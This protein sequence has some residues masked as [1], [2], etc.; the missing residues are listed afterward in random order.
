MRAKEVMGSVVQ[1]SNHVISRMGVSKVQTSASLIPPVTKVQLPVKESGSRLISKKL[2]NLPLHGGKCIRRVTSCLSLN[3]L[4]FASGSF[5]TETSNR[6]GYK[7]PSPSWVVT[8]FLG[9]SEA[10]DI[11]SVTRL[12]GKCS[13][14]CGDPALSQLPAQQ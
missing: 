1:P 6:L 7:V 3:H 10:A 12:A 13:R 11:L 5:S 9:G 4:P 2:Q 14:F 8:S